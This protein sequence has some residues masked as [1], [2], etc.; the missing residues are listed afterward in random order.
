MLAQAAALQGKSLG[1][2][3]TQVHNEAAARAALSGSHSQLAAAAQT[4]ENRVQALQEELGVTVMAQI[5][6]AHV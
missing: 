1:E 4:L 3:Q 6:R 2:L 5:G